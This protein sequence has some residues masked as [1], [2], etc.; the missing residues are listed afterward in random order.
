MG[1][2]LVYRLKKPT[3]KKHLLY[4]IILLNSIPVFSENL[5][6]N[7]GLEQ[8]VNYSPSRTFNDNHYI[9]VPLV[10][11]WCTPT[12][13]T[14]DFF[15]SNLSV[16]GSNDFVVKAHSGQGRIGMIC[17]GQDSQNYGADYKEYA[18]GNLVSPLVKD[19]LYHVSFYVKADPRSQR[20]I[21]KIGMY[22]SADS[23]AYSAQTKLP[24]DPQIL[25]P[26]NRI[27]TAQDDWVQIS[28]TYKAKGG[29]RFICIGS[30]S[31]YSYINLHA[32]GLKPLSYANVETR[33]RTAGYYYFDDISIEKADSSYTIPKQKHE[34]YLFLVDV[35]HSMAKYGKLDSL[36]QGF[37]KL[38]PALPASAEMAIVTYSST[39]RLALP[40]CSVENAKRIN[41]A[42]DSLKA[43]GNTD[44]TH[45]L[46]FA[47]GYLKKNSAK[48]DVNKMVV[49]TDGVFPVVPVAQDLVQN[50]FAQNN[51][52]FN[53]LQFGP[54]V[55]KDLKKLCHDTEGQ[56]ELETEKNVHEK[57][58]GITHTKTEDS[59]ED[60]EKKYFTP[61]A[62]R[63]S[64]RQSRINNI[65]PTAIYYGVGIIAVVYRAITMH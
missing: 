20:A 23:I 37:K 11:G 6:V 53:A 52:S 57:I 22:I 50:T 49:L 58:R 10:F 16:T 3:M 38:V 45:A 9:A 30:F 54:T 65:G 27:I 1:S 26:A 18:M 63:K 28:G 8:A 7:G 34:H 5:V 12:P 2:Y 15:N 62:V 13:A 55:N 48:N 61:E 42:I 21:G 39:S 40:F 24:Y 51:I 36:K 29:E 31:N 44:F 4:S 64:Q 35:S 19:Q 33:V 46:Q 25:Q 60:L 59:V 17:A 14:A 32:M 56:Y 43:D 41:D 47:Y